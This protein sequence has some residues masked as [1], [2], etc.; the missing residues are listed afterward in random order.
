MYARQ[1]NNAVLWILQGLLALLLLFAGVA[2]FITPTD[3]LS[4]QSPLPAA[5]LQF[6][7]MCE[8]LGALGLLL[9]SLTGIRPQLTSLAALGLVVIMV[10]ATITTILEMGVVQALFPFVV[11]ILTAYVGYG[12]ASTLN[13]PVEGV[14]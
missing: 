3:Q 4:A 11:G 13:Q 8:V 14:G 2:K 9:P 10:G 7:G 1:P 12:R 6:I 5:F